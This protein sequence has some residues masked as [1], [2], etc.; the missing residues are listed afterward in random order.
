[1]SR[2]PT[3]AALAALPLA[4][5]CGP[6]TAPAPAP[7]PTVAAAEAPAPP[8][9]LATLAD[10]LA[11]GRRIFQATCS[12][13]HSTDPPPVNAP[14][15]SHVAMHYRERY[16]DRAE[17]LAAMAAYVRAPAE[18][19]SALPAR[20]IQR[21]GVMP[22]LPLPADQLHAVSAYV[23][24]LADPAR[25]EGGAGPEARGGGHGPGRGHGRGMMMH[26]GPGRGNAG[27]GCARMGTPR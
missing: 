13:C 16:P 18:E 21:F 3:L 27:A 22:A 17:A 23:W 14:P 19:R 9:R 1:M 11:E 6:G 7:A 24:S 12:A 20:A 10:T 8:A 26:A 15:M 5:A 4:A 2:I 25:M